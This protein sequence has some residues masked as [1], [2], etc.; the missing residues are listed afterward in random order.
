MRSN[1]LRVVED[2]PKPWYVKRGYRNMYKAPAKRKVARFDYLCT[3]HIVETKEFDRDI[4]YNDCHG[5]YIEEGN[6]RRNASHKI[7]W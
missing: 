2:E 5:Y 1:S 4:Y 7:N 6:C 3:D